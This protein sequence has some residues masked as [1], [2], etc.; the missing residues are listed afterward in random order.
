MDKENKKCS[1]IGKDYQPCEWMKKATRG[2]NGHP[3]GI[4]LTCVVTM[5]DFKEF[6]GGAVYRWSKGKNNLVYMNFCPFCGENIQQSEW[7]K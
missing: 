5:G 3:I 4:S 1:F 6:T 7:S 2:V